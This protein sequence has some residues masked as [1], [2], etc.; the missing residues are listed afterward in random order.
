MSLVMEP[1]TRAPS[2]PPDRPPNRQAEKITGR[3]YV[4]HSQLSCMRSCPRKFAFQYVEKVPSA[5]IPSSL[6]FGGSIHA[7]LEL[8]F[9]ARLEG[10]QTTPAALLSAYHDAWHRQR[11]QAGDQVPVRF[12][13]GESDDTLHALAD[14]IIAS[15]LESPLASP[16]GT[17]VGV[18]EELRVVLDPE[19]PDLLARVDLVTV[20]D[21]SLHVID[22]KTSRSKWTDQ[23]AEESSEQLLLYGQ[24]VSRMS[25]HLGVPVKLH[26]AILTK[27]KAPVIQLIPVPTN[28][29]R[30]ASIK[31]SVKQ[32]WDAMQAGHFYPNP[33]P[34]NCAT[35]PFKNRCPVFGDKP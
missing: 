11:Q 20:T 8:Y 17:I 31:D 14:R 2:P 25:Q 35:C 16:K 13:K 10:L 5:F 28:A 33:S 4:S 34:Q 15:F 6:I 3:T 21:G 23:K 1:R 30:V 29:S 22:F 9:R 12:N 24:T 27:A 18:E 7:A 19:L 26:F 32:V